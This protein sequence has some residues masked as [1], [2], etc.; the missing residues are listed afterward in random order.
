MARPSKGPAVGVYEADARQPEGQRAMPDG[1]RL[2]G[3]SGSI[4]QMESE[5]AGDDPYR[6]QRRETAQRGGNALL[7]LSE[8]IVNRPTTDCPSNDTSPDC[9][10]SGQSWYRVR[11]EE[12]ACSPEATSR[13][14]AL[15]AESGRGG[16][17]ILFGSPKKTTSTVTS[18]ASAPP[19]PAPRAGVALS[20]A[21]LKTKV[22]AMMQEHVAREVIL[23]FVRGQALTRRLTAEEI[24][25]WT[26]AGIPD[27]VI[28][29]AAS[30]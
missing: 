1:C 7:A 18:P 29:S 14:A 17:T 15:P 19:A 16:I 28:E 11:F 4:D 24:I 30:R 25:D 26:R 21:E 23:A 3:T 6:R 13:L 20:P 10:K 12:F 9:L 22:L 5:R 2:I 8:T 27:A